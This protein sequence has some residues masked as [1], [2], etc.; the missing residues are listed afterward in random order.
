MKRLIFV[1]LL[2]VALIAAP[3]FASAQWWLEVGPPPA[4][5]EAP[6]FYYITG[7]PAGTVATYTTAVP[8]L[9]LTGGLM[10]APD[11]TGVTGFK[12]NLPSTWVPTTSGL[13][14]NVYACDGVSCSAASP[15]GQA[16]KPGPAL[17]VN[18]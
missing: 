16:S 15:F 12:L 1:A 4:G 6:V 9:T 7:M 18:Q 14:G 10:V 13:T 5:T 11:P 3:I 8:W 2:F 17:L